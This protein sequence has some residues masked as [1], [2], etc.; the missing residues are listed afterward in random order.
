M[1]SFFASFLRAARTGGKRS[2]DACLRLCAE[3]GFEYLDYSPDFSDEDWLT[4]VHEAAEA[5]GK[6]GVSIT[7][8]HA[9]FNF[10]RK[11][12]PERFRL[13]LDRAAEG[14]RILGAKDLVFHFDE[15]HPPAGTAF[16]PETALRSAR[17]VLS[18]AIEKTVSFG[19]NAALE[20]TFEDH[21]RVGP[22]ER[23]HLCAPIEEL[24]A[25]IDMFRDSRVTCCWDFGH[26]H[27]QF[28]GMHADM[29]RR[30]GRRITCTHVHDNYYGKDLHLMPFYGQLDWET[31]IPA[32]AGTG[33]GGTLAFEAGYG[34]FP[35]EL[36]GE[37]LGMSKHAMD[38]LCSYADCTAAGLQPERALG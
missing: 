25:A 29:I 17:E 5:A 7:Q 10:Y 12:P 26:A 31:L 21:H 37:F 6:Y 32:L 30:M 28:G 34:R 4:E 19:I 9:P 13:L 35:D 11:D 15:Y 2:P 22:E 33:Y 20:N 8:C 24:E 23:S 1:P 36:M 14:A 16:D 27:L 3:A 38:I 18:D